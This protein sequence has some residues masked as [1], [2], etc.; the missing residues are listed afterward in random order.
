MADSAEAVPQKDSAAMA[1]ET[2]ALKRAMSEHCASCNQSYRHRELG[3]FGK[4]CDKVV[5]LWFNPLSKL[6]YPEEW[7]ERAGPSRSG[8]YPFTQNTKLGFYVRLPSPHGDV[9]VEFFRDQYEAWYIN[10]YVHGH[11]T[12]LNNPES[13]FFCQCATALEMNTRSFALAYGNHGI[14]VHVPVGKR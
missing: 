7:L 12:I 1:E 5:D 4:R 8:P 3:L 10:K 13:R 14:P 11:R 9:D 2:D 6:F